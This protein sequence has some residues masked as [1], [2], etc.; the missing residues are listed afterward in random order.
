MNVYLWGSRG[1][2]PNSI[3]ERHVTQKIRNALKKSIKKNLKNDVDIDD[4][5]Q[6]DLTFSERGT[7]GS[8]TACVEIQDNDLTEA[9]EYLLC[10]AGSGLR[11]FGVNIIKSGKTG[12]FHIFMSHLHWDHIHGFPFFVPAFNPANTINIYGCHPELKEAFVYQQN[13]RHFPLRLHEMRATINFHVLEINKEYEIC[14][15]KINM[16]KQNHPGISY[17]YSFQKNGKKIIYSTDSEHNESME[18]PHYPFYDFFDKADLLIFDAQYELSDNM[19]DKKDW[20]HSSG[21]IGV[22][23]AK[24]VKA[25]KLCLFHNDHTNSDE[26]LEKMYKDTLRYTILSGYDSLELFQAYD[27]LSITI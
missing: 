9:N 19:G 14:G 10:D 15:Y 7:Y 13:F 6:N 11:D 23:I 20:G 12:V 25:K 27:G 24:R 3:T 21:M 18:D 17:G 26:V 22:E 16:I 1:S 8:N 4:F 5:M 2:L